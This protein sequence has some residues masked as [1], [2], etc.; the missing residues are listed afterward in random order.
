MLR[1]SWLPPV[2]HILVIYMCVRI[3]STIFNN[4]K[5]MKFNYETVTTDFDEIADHQQ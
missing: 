5:T 1:S 3:Y 2:S 4:S